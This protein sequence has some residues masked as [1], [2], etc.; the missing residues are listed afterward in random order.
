MTEATTGS[1]E[2][3]KATPRKKRKSTNYSLEKYEQVS[4][5]IGGQIKEVWCEVMDGFISPKA[6]MA[7]VE[8]D[9]MQGVFR[10]VR[11]ATPAY[12][13]TV[14]PQEPVWSMEKVKVEKN[15]K[16]TQDGA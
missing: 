9:K 8:E 12:A 4:L 15:G 1:T 16:K 13:A 7:Q 10:V 14:I 3:V 11:I 6:A 2:Q 5:S